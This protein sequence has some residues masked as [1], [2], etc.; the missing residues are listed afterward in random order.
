[1]SNEVRASY[2][3]LEQLANRFAR[4]QNEIQQ[5]LQQVRSAMQPLENGSWIGRGYDAFI[6]E[7]RSEVVPAATRLQQALGEAT[8]TTKN[9]VQTMQQAD[10]EA[11]APFQVR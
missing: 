2:S 11:S 1:M 7:M 3:E 8:N 9:I 6:R 4:S 5:M 10:E